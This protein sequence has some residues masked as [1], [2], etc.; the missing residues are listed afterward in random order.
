MN[1][2]SYFND[3]GNTDF[4]CKIPLTSLS[5]VALP[6]QTDGYAA[7]QALEFYIK[8][9]YLFGFWGGKIEPGVKIQT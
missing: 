6:S 4:A 7:A 8:Y 9:W 3:V 2:S 5:P 1:N